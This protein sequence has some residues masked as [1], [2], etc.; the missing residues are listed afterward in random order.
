MINVQFKLT[1]YLVLIITDI[2][3]AVHIY[4][5]WFPDKFPSVIESDPPAPAHPCSLLPLSVLGASGAH[6]CRNFCIRKE[7]AG[8]RLRLREAPLL[9]GR[10]AGLLFAGWSG[11]NWPWWPVRGIFSPQCRHSSGALQGGLSWRDGSW[12]VVEM[13]RSCS[14]W[15]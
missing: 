12:A 7:R 3:S 10:R 13:T 1:I 15:S 11:C 2:Y 8:R 6:V 5:W 9:F 4:L 14:N